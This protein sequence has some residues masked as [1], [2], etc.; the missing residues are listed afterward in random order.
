MYLKKPRVFNKYHSNARA[1]AVYIG[2]GSAWGN[3]YVIDDRMDRDTVCDLY[4]EY[5]D[6]HPELIPIIKKE[7]RGKDLLCFC[8]PKRCHGDILLK[9]ANEPEE[10]DHG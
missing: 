6:R 10:A 9:I 4:Q 1:D 3:P 7:L 5:I 2:R 8:K